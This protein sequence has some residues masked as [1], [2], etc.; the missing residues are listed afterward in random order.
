MRRI[1]ARINDSYCP[2]TTHAESSLRVWYTDNGDR[3]LADVAVDDG[4]SEVNHG[5]VVPQ[6][7]GRRRSG[8]L[9]DFQQGVQLYMRD[10]RLTT[11]GLQKGVRINEVRGSDEEK[12]TQAAV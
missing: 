10:S 12:S 3:G 4:H 1:D 5:R 6:S 11:E 8:G 7:G 9:H 2:R